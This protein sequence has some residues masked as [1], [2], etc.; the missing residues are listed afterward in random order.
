[1]NMDYGDTDLRATAVWRKKTPPLVRTPV[2]S[3]GPDVWKLID[4]TPSLDKNSL[5]CNLL[6]CSHFASTC[7]IAELDG[8]IMGWLSGYVPPQRQDTL[9]VWQICVGQRARGQGLAK[10]LV[11]DVLARSGSSHIRYLECT[12]TEGNTASWGLFESVARAMGAEARRSELFSRD[13]H[14]DGAH[15]SEIALTIGPFT[16]DWVA[17]LRG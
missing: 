5:Y 7:A 8:S 12:I 15:D 3:D 9:F 13:V 10:R 14:F 1:M 4:S 17:S 2:A 11:A 16:Q 6:Q